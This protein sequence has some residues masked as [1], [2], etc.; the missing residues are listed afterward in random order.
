MNIFEAFIETII[1][2]MWLACGIGFAVCMIF[3]IF[4]F[5]QS[6]LLYGFSSHVA[7]VIFGTF[8]TYLFHK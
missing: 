2:I 7:S 6:D 5:T 4:C 8:A 3:A 1:A